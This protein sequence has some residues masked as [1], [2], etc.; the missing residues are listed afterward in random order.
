M[1]A[2]KNPGTGPSPFLRFGALILAALMLLG[3]IAGAVA[4]LLLNR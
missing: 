3:A 4:W 1:S 2:K